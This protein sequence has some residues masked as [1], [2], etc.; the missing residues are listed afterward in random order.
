MNLQEKKEKK[1]KK[2]NKYLKRK[3][4]KKWKEKAEKERAPRWNQQFQLELKLQ[5]KLVCGFNHCWRNLSLWIFVNFVHR[6]GRKSWANIH[7]WVFLK[8]KM[9][10]QIFLPN[11]PNLANLPHSVKIKNPLK[12]MTIKHFKFCFLLKCLKSKLRTFWT[13][14]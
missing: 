2:K 10:W 9:S 1:K 14:V 8:L 4:E 7:N 11:L 13:Q 5:R 3:E 6:H 12:Y